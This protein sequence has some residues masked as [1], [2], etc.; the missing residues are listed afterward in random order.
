M[1]DGSGQ[2]RRTGSKNRSPF[3]D[4]TNA[5]S[6]PGKFGS[7]KVV[8]KKDNKVLKKQP[9]LPPAK[10]TKF[11]EGKVS[12]KRIKKAEEA[13]PSPQ[14]PGVK[15]HLK[16]FE[17]LKSTN[18][19]LKTA[20]DYAALN[21][22]AQDLHPEGVPNP[23]LTAL[24]SRV[25]KGDLSEKQKLHI[26]KRLASKPH[27]LGFKEIKNAERVIDLWTKDEAKPIS[28]RKAEHIEVPDKDPSVIEKLK[29]ASANY[30][31]KGLDKFSGTLRYC[32][33]YEFV[34]MA[35]ASAFAH[36]SPEEQQTMTLIITAV[37]MTVV[38][39]KA[40]NNLGKKLYN[41]EVTPK[42]ALG[43]GIALLSSIQKED[44]ES[45]SREA[46]NDVVTFGLTPRLVKPYLPDVGKILN[47]VQSIVVKK[48]ASTSFEGLTQG[49]K[50]GDFSAFKNLDSMMMTGAISAIA[51]GNVEE[52]AGSVIRGSALEVVIPI[53]GILTR[54]ML[55]AP[56]KDVVKKLSL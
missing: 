2:I 22:L 43:L 20:E 28:K 51:R 40:V 45:L 39:N 56:I 47:K 23:M 15:P 54:D 30:I 25:A 8:E 12:V 34:S 53:V 1:A 5:P 36:K 33:G 37:V 38:N 46:M 21:K 44:I 9:E 14:A 11:I 13:P 17:V 48:V 10:R 7:R 3:K 31:S 55:A 42:Q 19:E 49:A 26:A 18:P 6:K 4:I 32:I 50:E 27:Y 52:K 35:V 41:G 16:L 29:A 24:E